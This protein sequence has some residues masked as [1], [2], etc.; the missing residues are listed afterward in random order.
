MDYVRVLFTYLVEDFMYSSYLLLTMLL[1]CL[2]YQG[3][4]EIKVKRNAQRMPG[5]I[6]FWG[7]CN[8]YLSVGGV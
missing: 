2:I 3:L 7:L 5:K 4:M 6:L 1:P 8:A